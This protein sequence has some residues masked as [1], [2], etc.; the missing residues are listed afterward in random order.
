MRS[1]EIVRKMVGEDLLA[2]RVVIIS[3]VISIKKKNQ[4]TPLV[5]C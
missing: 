2:V 1:N 5:A 3:V 4:G